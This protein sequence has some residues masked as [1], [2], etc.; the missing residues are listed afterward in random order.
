MGW[1]STQLNDSNGDG[2]YDQV[3]VTIGN[4]YP[5]YDCELSV[6]VRNGAPC[7]RG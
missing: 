2:L 4:A 6:T 7:R 3:I 1:C 5:C